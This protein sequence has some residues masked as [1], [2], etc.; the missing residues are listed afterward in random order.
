MGMSPPHTH[1]HKA[2][3]QNTKKMVMSMNVLV[4]GVCDA[5]SPLEKD[6]FRILHTAAYIRAYIHTYMHTGIVCTLM[7]LVSA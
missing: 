5:V 4:K 3:R 1:T 6:A 7:S 2:S